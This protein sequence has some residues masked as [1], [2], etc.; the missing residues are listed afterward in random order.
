VKGGAETMNGFGEEWAL[1]DRSS[2]LSKHDL[3]LQPIRSRLCTSVQAL[4]KK[5][6][7][8]IVAPQLQGEHRHLP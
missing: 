6:R 4:Q 8:G 7:S 2:L 3:N 1:C 5:Q